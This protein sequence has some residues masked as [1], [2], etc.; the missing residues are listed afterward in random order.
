MPEAIPGAGFLNIMN[1]DLEK[2]VPKK[3]LN[4]PK[5]YT[6]KFKINVVINNTNILVFNFLVSENMIR[7]HKNK[8]PKLPKKALTVPKKVCLK[9]AMYRFK[10]ETVKK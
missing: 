3:R 5:M 2:A 6:K 7:T 10:W 8:M 4:I 9:G 1:A